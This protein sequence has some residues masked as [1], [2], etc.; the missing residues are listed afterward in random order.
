MY[1]I[2]DLNSKLINFVLQRDSYAC[3]YN[4][5]EMYAGI[6]QKE[7]SVQ[8]KFYSTCKRNKLQISYVL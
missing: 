4:F 2:L 7:K 3:Y 6:A 8:C 5:A 1:F